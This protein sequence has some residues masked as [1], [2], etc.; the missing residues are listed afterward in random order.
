MFRM[1]WALL[2]ACCAFAGTSIMAQSKKPDQQNTKAGGSGACAGGSYCADTSRQFRPESI[3][4]PPRVNQ[5]FQDREFGSRLIRVTDE[6]GID[7]NLPGLSFGS[8]A[9]AETNEWGK[10]DPS[11]G[12]NGGYYFYVMTS[13]GGAVLFSMDAATMRVTPHC[14]ALRTCR[15]PVDD[16]FSYVDPKILY[17]QF[18]SNGTIAAYN[19]ATG[20]QTT[21]YDLNKC[22]NLPDDLSGYSGAI[23][24]SGDD[25]KF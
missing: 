22:P 24:N 19:V 23:S 14:G 5:I 13:G 15:L 7:G 16:S 12:P 10:F 9:S 25:T 8:N 2:L 4:S 20:K 17:G 3:D 21:V 1:T 18:G 11:L 6:N